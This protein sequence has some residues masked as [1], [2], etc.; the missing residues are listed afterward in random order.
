MP[1]RAGEAKRGVPRCPAVV[2]GYTFEPADVVVFGTLVLIEGVLSFD[3]AAILAAMV[4]KLP[5]DQRARALNYGLAGAYV[6]RVAAV[7]GAAFLIRYPLLRALGGAYLVYLAVKHLFFKPHE[8]HAEPTLLAR[9]G[10]SPF[11]ALV[12]GLLLA[13][14]AFALDQVIVAVAFTEKIHLIV[15]ASLVAIVVLRFSATYMGRLMEW[16]PQLEQL[17]YLAVGFVGLKLVGVEAAHAAGFE[18]FA[19]PK[20]I[21]VA[22]TLSLLVVPVLGKLAWDRWRTARA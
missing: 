14:M 9:L 1:A 12:G 7:L 4:R 17:A 15:A 22:V 8:E 11:W 3:N 18:S 21:T 16:F 5:E 2:L 19:V 10:L 13:D 20:E 6:F